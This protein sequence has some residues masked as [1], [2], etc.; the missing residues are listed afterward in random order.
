MRCLRSVLD[1]DRQERA[2]SDM[3]GD[4]LARHAFLRQRGE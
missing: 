4:G 3:L 2:Q 1:G